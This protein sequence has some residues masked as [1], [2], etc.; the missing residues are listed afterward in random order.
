MSKHICTYGHKHTQRHIHRH[1]DTDTHR[2]RER[3]REGVG[4]GGRERERERGRDR[5]SENEPSRHNMTA[6]DGTGY[7]LLITARYLLS[8]KHWWSDTESVCVRCTHSKS[9]RDS[10]SARSKGLLHLVIEPKFGSLL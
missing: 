8:W 1:T 6:P 7:A 4:R 9:K 5:E 2:H 3:E 10:L